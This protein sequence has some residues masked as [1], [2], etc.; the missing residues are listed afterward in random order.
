MKLAMIGTGKLGSAL[1]AGIMAR[2]VL[3]SSDVGI[4]ERNAGK[5]AEMT[6]RF[7]VQAL[8]QEDLHRAEYILIAVQPLSFPAV[9]KWAAQYDASYISTMAGVTVDTLRR[10]LNTER[11]VRAMPNLAAT[12]GHSQ[13]ALSATP[14]AEAAGDLNFAAQLFGA[15]GDTYILPEY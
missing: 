11:V 4:L 8:T 15:V 7:G 12:I 3:S 9:A 13:T 10:G 5:S 1:L 2:G 6:E 14:A